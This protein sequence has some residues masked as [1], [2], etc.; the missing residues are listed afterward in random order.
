MNNYDNLLLVLKRFSRI[1]ITGPQ[2]SGTTYTS[3]IVAKDLGYKCYDESV[4]RVNDIELFNRYIKHEKI[5]MQ[6]PDL[7][8][9]LEEINYPSTIAVFMDRNNNDIRESEKRVNWEG[10]PDIKKSY[11]EKY[12]SINFDEFKQTAPMRKWVFNN[13]QKDKMQIP[14][15]QV[16]YEILEQTSGF[17]DK[18]YRKSFHIKQWK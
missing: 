4:I 3:H 7:T 5:V 14:H 13:I 2:R 9:R 18:E 17:R 16:P 12:P 15:L 6:C 1:L 10:Y 8:L 11:Q